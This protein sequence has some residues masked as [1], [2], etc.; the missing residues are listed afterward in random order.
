MS[1]DSSD[2]HDAY[3]ERMKAEGE[4]MD[5]EDGK[6]YIQLVCFIGLNVHSSICLSLYTCIY[7]SIYIYIYIY[8]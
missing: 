4:E 6:W 3:L 2:E 1:G 5:S 8:I 7:L